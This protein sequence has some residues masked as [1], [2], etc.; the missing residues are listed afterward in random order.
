MFYDF[1][2]SDKGSNLD[3]IFHRGCTNHGSPL[4]WSRSSISMEGIGNPQF[5]APQ[6]AGDEGGTSPNTIIL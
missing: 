5:G 1:A 6:S 4:E 2:T 3:S